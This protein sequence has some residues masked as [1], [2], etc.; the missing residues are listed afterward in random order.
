VLKAANKIRQRFGAARR[1][2]L[3]MPNARNGAVAALGAV[4]A[5]LAIPVVRAHGA[6][7]PGFCA[8]PATLVDDACNARLT[9][10]TADTVN[11][12]IT[13][14]PVGGG[15][16]LTLAGTADAYLRSDGFGDAPPDAIQQWDATI[17]RVSGLDT[18]GP[19][20]YGNAKS[21]VFLPRTL[22]ELATHFPLDTI[23]VR[24]TPDTTNSGTF[25]LVSVQPMGH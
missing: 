9:S 6:P 13:G 23:V 15:T 2:D 14:T 4:I 20:W 11:G 22:D 5:V 18:D 8:P 17:D 16:P 25:P 19:D 10:V 21:R 12:T 7:P 1:E 3:P 24:F